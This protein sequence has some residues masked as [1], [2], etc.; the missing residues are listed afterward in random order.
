MVTG[1][2]GFILR[3]RASCPQCLFSRW[4][5]RSSFLTHLPPCVGI[6]L[7]AQSSVRP[8]TVTRACLSDH[9]VIWRERLAQM[10]EP[11]SRALATGGY[12]DANRQRMRTV[13]RQVGWPS[14]PLRPYVSGF[15]DPAEGDHFSRHLR[16]EWRW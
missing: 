11:H 2:R 15:G 12:G 14:I 7:Q 16:P 4:V 3:K 1:R 5:R 10:R 8:D 13:A 9:S 6:W